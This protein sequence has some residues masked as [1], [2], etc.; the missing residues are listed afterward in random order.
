VLKLSSFCNSTSNGAEY[1][2][3]TIRLSSM[4]LELKRITIVNFRVNE[5]SNN[6]ASG[7]SLINSITNTSP[8]HEYRESMM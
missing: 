6:S 2:L 1:K 3:K 4:Q 8:G 5:G 7:S